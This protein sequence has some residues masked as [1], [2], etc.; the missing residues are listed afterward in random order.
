MLDFEILVGGSNK[1]GPFQYGENGKEIGTF[2]EDV[3]MSYRSTN[4]R[5]HYFSVADG[6]GSWRDDGINPV[7]FTKSMM[8]EIK[9]IIEACKNGEEKTCS[10]LIQEAYAILKEEHLKGTHHYG[11]CTFNLAKIDL[12]TG[13]ME[14]ANIGDSAL[15]VLSDGTNFSLETEPKQKGFNCPYQIG[16]EMRG[17]N[18][19]LDCKSDTQT[20]YHK[21]KKGDILLSATDGVWDGMSSFSVKDAMING[22]SN[23][24]EISSSIYFSARAGNRKRDDI[25]VIL[26]RVI[27]A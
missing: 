15:C 3:Y 13:D 16:I 11:S 10:E 5:Y 26:A 2:G 8:E 20:Y 9:K 24:R 22:H 1:V 23:L 6:V 14:I 4:K 12:L 19:Y 17:P 18:L 21:L 7:E 25:T 27:E